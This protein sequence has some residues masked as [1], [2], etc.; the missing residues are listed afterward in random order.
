M[1]NFQVV[2]EEF[3]VFG[4]E[5]VEKVASLIHEGNVRRIIIKD[6]KGNTFLE[7]PL[8]IATVGTLAAPVLAG[9]GAIAALIANFTLVVERVKEE[10]AGAPKTDHTEPPSAGAAPPS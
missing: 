6:E 1:A 9:L 7:I 2:Y 5:L 3:R 10:P 4:R 8:T